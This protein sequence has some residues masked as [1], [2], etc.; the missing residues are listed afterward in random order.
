MRFPLIRSFFFPAAFILLCSGLVV[1][2]A[3]TAVDIRGTL[4][5]GWQRQAIAGTPLPLGIDGIYAGTSGFLVLGGGDGWISSNGKSW[6]APPAPLSR[7]ALKQHIPDLN[8]VQIGISGAVHGDTNAVK[9]G[10]P[11]GGF[12]GVGSYQPP[13]K[14]VTARRAEVAVSK[15]GTTWRQV[16]GK[17]KAFLDSTMTDVARGGPGWV[18]VGY[19]IGP[20][21]KPLIWTSSDGSHWQRIPQEPAVKT[22]DEIERLLQG[23]AGLLAI[24]TG[25]DGPAH[26]W[27]SRDGV[28]WKSSPS[29]PFGGGVAQQVTIGGPGYLAAGMEDDAPALWTSRD[30]LHWTRAAGEAS[31][32]GDQTALAGVAIRGHDI[33]VVG[34]YG[35]AKLGKSGVKFSPVIPSAWVWTPQSSAPK[36]TPVP[37]TGTISPKRF[38][39]RLSDLPAGYVNWELGGWP[40]FCDDGATLCRFVNRAVGAYGAYDSSFASSGPSLP[41]T[42]IQSMAIQGTRSSPHVLASLGTRLIL[43]WRRGGTLQAVPAPARIGQE[44]R[45]YRGNPPAVSTPPGGRL[46]AYAVEWRDGTAI[47]QVWVEQ[48]PQRPARTVETLAMNLARAQWRH[49]RDAR[50]G[51]E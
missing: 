5:N 48:A 36:P 47:G 35:T 51:R 50:N 12:I 49:W 28:H 2:H 45:V 26:T 37:R 22:Y 38:R 23:P 16:T 15:D 24:A 8:L 39:L 40:D 44:T 29:D 9:A 1:A 27:T 6:K 3:G 30:G 43:W 14:P 19:S 4:A 25:L 7:Y 42:S 46:T 31:F 34:R 20:R 41:L 11:H 21:N 17:G 10:G 13:G 18:A 32:P 33:V